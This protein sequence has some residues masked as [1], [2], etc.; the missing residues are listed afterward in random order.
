[1]IFIPNA[2]KCDTVVVKFKCNHGI[3]NQ[4]LNTNQTLTVALP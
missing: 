1:M 2:Q 4:L 3:L